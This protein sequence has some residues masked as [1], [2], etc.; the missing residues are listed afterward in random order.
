MSNEVV[1]QEYATPTSSELLGCKL[2]EGIVVNIA[3]RKSKKTITIAQ[4]IAQIWSMSRLE[5]C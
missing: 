1:V 3:K 5:N 4:L 2:A